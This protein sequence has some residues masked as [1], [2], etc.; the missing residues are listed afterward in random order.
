MPAP[1]LL[2]RAA[3]S[4]DIDLARSRFIG[5]ILNHVETRHG[6]GCRTVL[7]DNGSETEGVL[8]VVRRAP[9]VA[10]NLDEAAWL[11][12]AVEATTPA[13]TVEPAPVGGEG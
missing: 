5:V 1:G 10:R 8:S 7:L 12:L 2:M 13:G 6:A 4:R 9:P 11:T 3:A